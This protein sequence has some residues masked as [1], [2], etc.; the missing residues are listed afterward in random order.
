MAEEHTQPAAILCPKCRTKITDFSVDHRLVL[1]RCS[2]CEL[3]W[4]DSGE[5]ELF[6]GS[7]AIERGIATFDD[8][9]SQEGESSNLWCPR[10][11]DSS[12]QVVSLQRHRFWNCRGCQGQLV[13]DETAKCLRTYYVKQRHASQGRWDVSRV[14]NTSN[15]IRTQNDD[16][17]LPTTLM[18]ELLAIPLATLVGALFELTGLRVFLRF[19]SMPLHELGHAAASWF[20][21]ISATPLPFFTSWDEIRSNSVILFFCTLWTAGIVTAIHWRSRVMILFFA[22]ALLIQFWATFFVPLE[23]INENRI[24]FGFTGEIV[25]SALLV[26]SFVYR[27]PPRLRWDFWR[28]PVVSLGGMLFGAAAMQWLQIRNDPSRIPWGSAI[29]TDENDGDLNKL[30]DLYHWSEAQIVSHYLLWIKLS[31][32][33]MLM[34]YLWNLLS[35]S[36]ARK[37][38]VPNDR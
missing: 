7:K 10:C 16:V 2:D 24:A 27:L 9:Q 4:F 5:F 22:A 6:V 33:W 37:D 18:I 26:A 31:F 15:V 32:A 8:E 11:P 20:A 29:S 1:N 12:L 38:S 21:G 14:S 35:T 28:F 13:S 36:S 34:H 25:F 23:R 19:L 3:S 30:R 17:E